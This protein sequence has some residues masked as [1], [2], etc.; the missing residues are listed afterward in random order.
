[1]LISL[2]WDPTVADRRVAD[3]IP[4]LS[5]PYPPFGPRDAAAVDSDHDDAETYGVGRHDDDHVDDHNDDD[6]Q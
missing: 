6:D 3:A 5:A 4:P 2:P 1:M